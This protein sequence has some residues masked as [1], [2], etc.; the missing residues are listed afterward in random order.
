MRYGIALLALALIQVPDA[1]AAVLALSPV[2]SLPAKGSVRYILS[3]GAS[4]TGSLVFGLSTHTWEHDGKRYLLKSVTETT[5]LA[6]L[7]KPARVVQTSRG[8]LVTGGLRPIE[9]RH[10]RANGE[11]DTAALDWARHL[12]SYGGHKETVSDGTQDMLSM[13]YQAVLV[14][15]KQSAAGG[16]NMPVAT[17]RKLES[18]HFAAL[19]EERVKLSG[20]E[21][22]AVHLSAK[23]GEDRIELWI[24]V[25]ARLALSLPLKIRFVDR[26]GEIFD[27]VM[28]AVD[29]KG[30]P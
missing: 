11:V 12:V 23:S 14:Q 25:D 30:T 7:L 26:Q 29:L 1:I 15:S 10:E 27:Q 4:G 5:G 19:G 22:R 3:K 2:A 17:G 8:E 6:A 28:D 20:G 9:F 13:Y 24:A 21:H 16:V 18:Y